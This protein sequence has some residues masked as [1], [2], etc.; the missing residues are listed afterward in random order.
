LLSA[1]AD[2]YDGPENQHYSVPKDVLA[3]Y[4]AYFDRCFNGGFLE[5]K[6]KKLTLAEDKVE[7]FETL[8]DYALQDL[9]LQ[10]LLSEII[11]LLHTGESTNER[12]KNGGGR[13]LCNQSSSYPEWLSFYHTHGLE[14]CHQTRK[15]KGTMLIITDKADICL[16]CFVSVVQGSIRSSSLNVA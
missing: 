5:A 8:L 11:S 13:H 7:N 9:Q 2:I 12:D 10:T 14:Q 15:D 1:R 3:H 16:F 4:S 6:E